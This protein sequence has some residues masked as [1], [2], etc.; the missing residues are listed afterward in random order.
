MAFRE[1][2]LVAGGPGT[3]KSTLLFQLAKQNPEQ[4]VWF[5]DNERKARRIG[6]YFGGIPSNMV[7][8]NTGNLTDAIRALEDEVLPAVRGL[9]EGTDIICIDMVD[10]WWDRAQQHYVQAVS[11]GEETLADRLTANVK[12]KIEKRDALIA[13]GR[14][15][16]GLAAGSS[17]EGFVEWPV[18]K[19]WHN[20]RLIEPIVYD[21]PC[22]VFATAGVRELRNDP[23]SP[24][25]DS[26]ERIALWTNFGG[27]A[28]GEKGNDYRFSTI[29][30][31]S[32]VGV[33]KPEWRFTL[34]KDQS[35]VLGK[36]VPMLKDVKLEIDEDGVFDLWQEF[37]SRIPG[38][39]YELE[40]DDAA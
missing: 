19:S 13:Q 21:T 10:M 3:G 18:I 22:H 26:A 7:V 5:F 31:L 4:R 12:E 17:F 1:T 11:D 23:K 34:V 29:L 35:R 37:A 8:L 16:G 30:G 36:Q 20:Q 40:A 2:V 6:R 14:N 27:V 24:M 39:V 32:R 28:L 15:V 25:N 38:G 9:P 33:V